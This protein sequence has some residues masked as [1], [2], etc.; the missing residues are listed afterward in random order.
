MIFAAALMEDGWSSGNVKRAAAEAIFHVDEHVGEIA[1]IDRNVL[2]L[3]YALAGRILAHID[4]RRLGSC[5]VEL[6]GAAYR[7]NRR[8]INGSSCR[9]CR[10]LFR[11]GAGGLLLFF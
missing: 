5:A 11:S 9:R 8:G 3:I 4:L 1:A 2:H 6:N 10:R 7:G